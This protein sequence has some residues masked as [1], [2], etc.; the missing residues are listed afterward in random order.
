MS[1][2]RCTD[3]DGELCFPQYG[4]GP[5]AH[6]ELNGAPIIGSTKP[7]PRD[8]WPANYQEDP[9]AP[10]HGTWWCPHCGEGKPEQLT[11]TARPACAVHGIFKLGNGRLL[12]C[13]QYC[14]GGGCG[15]DDPC[16]HK[17]HTGQ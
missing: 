11:A 3:P 15:S 10:G 8:Q 5:H 16:E 13:L 1:C 2:L 17:L 12:S 14:V 6:E 7:L 9:K 4:I